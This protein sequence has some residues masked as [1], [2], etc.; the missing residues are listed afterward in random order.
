MTAF[1]TKIGESL[2][3]LLD[4]FSESLLMSNW[5]SVL[6]ETLSTLPST[7]MSPPLKRPFERTKV[8]SGASPASGTSVTKSMLGCG[9][10]APAVRSGNVIKLLAPIS[11]GGSGSALTSKR[12]R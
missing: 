2:R 11:L 5:Q 1:G 12:F 7:Q 8:R 3:A 10:I 4:A 6:H 9:P